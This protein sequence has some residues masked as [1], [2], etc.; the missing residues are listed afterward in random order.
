MQ[1]NNRGVV[2]AL[3]GAASLW[4]CACSAKA[5]VVASWNFNTLTSTV[6]ATLQADGGAGVA[7]F[8]EFTSGVSTLTGTDVNAVVGDLAGQALTITGSSQNGKGVVFELNTTGMMQLSISMA[9]RR[10][11][12]GFSATTIDVW[13]GDTWQH[14]ASFDASTTQWQQHQFSLAQFAFMNNASVKVRLLVEGATSGSGNIRFDNLRFEAVPVPGPG[15]AAVIGAASIALSTRRAARGEKASDGV[16]VAPA[17]V[18]KPIKKGGVVK[19]VTAPANRLVDQSKY[20]GSTKP[21]NTDGLFAPL[22]MRPAFGGQSA[23][24]VS[25][26]ST[27]SAAT[28]SPP[29]AGRSSRG[30]D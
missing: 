12:S 16:R 26:P 27:P 13:N 2:A 18:V 14:A 20:G 10:S 7:K 29:K 3:V 21:A 24:P 22:G 23:A 28:V 1:R 11:A 30:S 4:L 17:V 8:A 19:P 9:A 25:S 5:D 15:G 6:P